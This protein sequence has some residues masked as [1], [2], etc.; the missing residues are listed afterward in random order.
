VSEYVQLFEE[1]KRR[2]IIAL[3]LEILNCIYVFSLAFVSH[4]LILFVGTVIVWKRTKEVET[5][6]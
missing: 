5:L 6:E 1:E 4:I 3:C 2:E